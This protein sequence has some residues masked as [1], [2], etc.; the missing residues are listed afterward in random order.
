[1]PT[2]ILI[3]TCVLC[4]AI[5]PLVLKSASRNIS[6]L[7]IQIIIAYVHSMF[8]PAMFLYLKASGVVAD[9]NAK[10]MFFAAVA[11]V[12][13]TIAS[14]SFSTAIQKAPVHIVMSFT[15]MYP[16]V[17]VLLSA[18]FLSESVTILKVVGIITVVV[19]V[20]LLSW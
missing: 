4:W 10:G 5:W 20:A 3:C 14:L 11:C 2:W 13:T 17:T 9:W 15:A 7:M 8:A 6:P 1:M 16:A 18:I 19:G 12:L